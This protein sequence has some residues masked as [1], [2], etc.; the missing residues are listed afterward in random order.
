MKEIIIRNSYGK[1]SNYLS[2]CNSVFIGKS[3]IKNFSTWR[4]KSHRS[5]KIRMQNLSWPYVYNFQEIYALL[6]KYKIAEQIADGEELSK[7]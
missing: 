7:K 5:S 2:L 1:A 3:L 6:S 4:T